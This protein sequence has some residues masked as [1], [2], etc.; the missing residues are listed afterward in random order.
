MQNKRFLFAFILVAFVLDCDAVVAEAV[1]IGKNLQTRRERGLGPGTESVDGLPFGEIGIPGTGAC[2]CFLHPVA[3]GFEEGDAHRVGAIERN[4]DEDAP[5][6]M[7]AD[8]DAAGAGALP[9][10]D[11]PQ[12]RVGMDLAFHGD[13]GTKSF[14]LSDF[15]PK[16]AG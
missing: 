11:L 6:R 8:G 13:K 4:R 2:Q 5:C 1:S 7:D 14:V 9:K 15:M 16:F 3:P 12:D 10:E